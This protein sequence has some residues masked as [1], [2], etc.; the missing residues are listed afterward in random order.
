MRYRKVAASVSLILARTRNKVSAGLCALVVA[1]SLISIGIPTISYAV[2][3]VLTATEDS[4][5]LD[6]NN[7][8]NLFPGLLASELGTSGPGSIWLSI[9]KFDL[10][11]L[12]GMTVNS[13]TL[14]LTSIF[15]HNSGTFVH[16]VYSSSDDSWTEG[17]V[18]GVNRPGDATLTLL[19][20]TH[21]SGT[22]QA[23]TWDVL[24]GVVGADGLAG[25]GN[26]LTLI[27]RPELSQAG[28]AFGPHFNDR[29]SLSGFPRLLAMLQRLL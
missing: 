14:E 24:A 26:V 12:T 28:N 29:E 20:S 3:L 23:Y 2:I 11:P 5:I 6:G 18:T 25:A 8:N 21:I 10:S 4:T 1:V 9:L 17:T 19:G 22:S 16:E 15:N 7:A 13:A 27:I